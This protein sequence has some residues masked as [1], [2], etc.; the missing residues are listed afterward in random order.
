MANVGGDGVVRPALHPVV[1]GDAARPIVVVGELR[2]FPGV[3][4][5]AAV[6]PGGLADGV[7]GRDAP[8]APDTSGLLGRAGAFG[9]VVGRLVV[10]VAYLRRHVGDTDD[11]ARD[12]AQVVGRVGVLLARPVEG[13]RRSKAP[14]QG[15]DKAP[16]VTSGRVTP[17]VVGLGAGEGPAGDAQAVPVPGV[18]LLDPQGAETPTP[19][20]VAGDRVLDVGGLDTPTA[21]RP[22]R[23][24]V[25]GLAYRVDMA[26]PFEVETSLPA[27]W[28]VVVVG[29]TGL[30]PTVYS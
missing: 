30:R 11:V 24:S 10:A 25:L 7:H 28:G 6:R 16:V 29:V 14:G 17:A 8:L 23:P 12:V 9:G 5:T 4:V 22:P 20:A 3:P 1:L 18:A 27:A 13:V 19:S 21:R 26:A 15:G 2:A